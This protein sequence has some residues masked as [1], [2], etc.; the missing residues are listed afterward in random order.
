MS[1]IAPN[2]FIGKPDQPTEADLATVLGPAKPAWDSLLAAMAEQH[3]VNTQEW[4]SYSH[5]AG[6]SLRLLRAKRTIVWLSPCDKCFC[7]TFIFGEHALQAARA[8]K[9]SAQAERALDEAVRYPEGTGVRLLVKAAKDLASV[10]KLAAAKLQ[11]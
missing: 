3:G 5:K 6:W 8:L 2:A 7:V 9:L 4:K 11:N 10:L 1:N